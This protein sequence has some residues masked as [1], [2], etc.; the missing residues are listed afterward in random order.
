MKTLIIAIIALGIGLFAGSRLI[1]GSTQAPAR[2]IPNAPAATAPSALCAAPPISSDSG[3]YTYPSDPKYAHLGFLGQLFTAASC[4][5]ERVKKIFGVTDG[6]YTLGSTIWLKDKPTATLVTTLTRIGFSCD[7][8]A[9]PSACKK[10]KLDATVPA[11]A[12]LEL[13]P[14]AASF[15][16]DDCRNCG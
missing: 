6:Q 4:G 2:A 14:F 13:E 1:A 3:R 9:A 16:Q 11:T 7:D 12:L 15:S 10:W 8:G 5:N